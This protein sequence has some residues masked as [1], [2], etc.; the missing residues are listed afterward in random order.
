MKPRHNVPVIKNH[1]SFFSFWKLFYCGKCL[2]A[3]G[4]LGA[5]S[6][7]IQV[8]ATETVMASFKSARGTCKLA[9]TIQSCSWLLGTRLLARSTVNLGNHQL[10][11]KNKSPRWSPYIY[12]GAWDWCWGKEVLFYL[13]VSTG[14]TGAERCKVL[15]KAVM[16]I[17]QSDSQFQ[18]SRGSKE[19]WP[20]EL[21]RL[22]KGR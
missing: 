10:G 22:S 4:A 17:R 1:F 9:W 5:L 19:V 8:T 14:S 20:R 7:P 12:S 16:P 15:K 6:I 2:T 13:M 3:L 21:Q 11:E 18:L